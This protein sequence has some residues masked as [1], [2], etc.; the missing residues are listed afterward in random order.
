MRRVY[1]IS[2]N[3][4]L[5]TFVFSQP[6]L[7]GY[8]RDSSTG[9][10][11]IGATII[12]SSSG[13]GTVTNTY[14]YYSLTL[15]Q[16]SAILQVSYVGYVRQTLRIA[17]TGSQTLNISLQPDSG[18][19][20][21]VVTSEE[22]L[23]MLPSMSTVKLTVEQINN[24]PATMG[25]TDIMKAIQL[26]P[27][28]SAGAEGSANVH[29]RGGGP[30][31]NLTLLDGVPLYNP[32]H[33]YGFFSVFNPE[34]INN[35]EVIKGGFPARYGGR[36]SSVIDVTMKE[37][38]NQSF[39]G[40]VTVGPLASKLSL[41]GPIWK[42]RTSFIVSGRRSY[43]GL[44]YNPFERFGDDFDIARDYA[45]Y[46]FNAKV[47][48]IFS[49]KSRLYISMY[50]GLDDFSSSDTQVYSP[51]YRST[52]A[53][54]MRWGNGVAVIRWNYVLHPKV[55]TNLSVSTNDFHFRTKQAFTTQ[56]TTND[57]TTTRIDQMVYR[58][59]ITDY[60]VKWD[61]D[62][63]PNAIHTIKAGASAIFHKYAPGLYRI[64]QEAADL[65]NG[66]GAEQ[67]DAMEY[68]FFVEDDMQLHRLLRLNVGVHQSIFTVQGR[69]YTST[70][71]R[72]S[73]RYTLTKG[74]SLKASFATMQQYNHLLTNTGVGLPTDL[75]VPTTRDVKPQTSEQWALGLVRATANWEIS[76]EG[77]TK[78][79]DGLIEYEE[80]AR[81][82]AT[83]EPWY[84]K[85][86]DGDGYSRG[87]EVLIQRKTGKLTGW[88]AYTLSKTQRQFDE[89]NG[90]EPFYSRYDRRHDLSLTGT[91]QFANKWSAGAVWIV[92]SG[93]RAT[94]IKGGTRGELLGFPYDRLSG[95]IYSNRN[96]FVLPTYH[97]LDLSVQWASIGEKLGHEVVLGVYNAY[98][99][100]NAFYLDYQR[101]SPA[102]RI[103][104]FPRSLLP[105]IPYMN[106]TVRF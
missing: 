41:E 62:Y 85:V 73:G 29:V 27:G 89:I 37:G 18:L 67:T 99:R 8:V 54:T 15:A 84:D 90:G 20:E 26:M 2:I 13:K 101:F 94:V 30:D 5:T 9:E 11:L 32:S 58:N 36:L 81:V 103:V 34:A 80:G 40:S 98:A 106:Y 38:S 79:M 48:H 17:L 105:I 78:Q 6:T 16:D 64:T 71:P 86:T 3:L 50:Q 104:Y 47:N 82:T 42:D 72:I 21:V 56:E 24:L 23:D 96:A 44:I 59:R 83:Y 45:F 55:F 61:A 87:L 7:S 100:E 53:S 102:D 43:I 39:G 92:S 12:D 65:S 28:I 33:L 35:I 31:Q 19:K 91:Y 63:Y 68:A 88:L 25:E 22:T 77:Y 95:I 10:N 76:L 75:W 69:T 4:L 70:Q 1:F 66:G 97:R 74:L 93:N 14:G 46:D 57:V 49:D 52:D 60:T 51:F